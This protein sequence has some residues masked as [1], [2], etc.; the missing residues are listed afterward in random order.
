[1]K[2]YEYVLA[3]TGGDGNPW[4]VLGMIETGDFSETQR[5]AMLESFRTLTGGDTHYGNP[6]AGRCC[7]PYVIDEM[8]IRRVKEQ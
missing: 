8:T 6:G 2:R 1:M 4:S 3:G 7:G 5:L